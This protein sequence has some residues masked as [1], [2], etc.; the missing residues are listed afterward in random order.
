MRIR[1]ITEAF[2]SAMTAREIVTSPGVYSRAIDLA[3]N[4]Q[5]V[6][7]AHNVNG[8]WNIGFQE[9]SSA[10]DANKSKIAGV[11]PKGRQDM[12]GKGDSQRVMSFVKQS[13]DDFVA[14]Y[15]PKRMTFS[16]DLS[17]GGKADLY[18]RMAQRYTPKDYQLDVT[19]RNGHRHFDIVHKTALNT[20]IGSS[21]Y[22]NTYATGA[23]GKPTTRFQDQQYVK[24]LERKAR[25]YPNDANISAELARYRDL[26]NEGERL[27]TDQ[28]IK[29]RNYTTVWVPRIEALRPRC[30]A[31]VDRII[32]TGRYRGKKP[33]IL[34]GI[35]DTVASVNP[36]VGLVE[37][38]S[39]PRMRIDVTVFWDAP[40]ETLTFVIAHELG[41]VHLG[42]DPTK[43]ETPQQSRQQELAADAFAAEIM[44]LFGYSQASV[45]RFMHSK[46]KKYREQEQ[47]NARPDSTHP[48]YDQR[49]Q[50]GRDMGIKLTRA[51]TDDLKD[52]V[53]RG[54]MQQLQHLMA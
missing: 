51:D 52:Y 12:T 6:F 30:N 45:F 1:E 54:G 32:K 49:I 38:G 9:Q 4:R 28:V 24:D 29:A 11:D 48:T 40:D 36:M 43:D 21:E 8:I 18:Q 20:R 37:L 34:V 10:G 14:K 23:P 7:V 39:L 27:S 13:M 53:S 25:E 16:A 41:H 44:K 5:I 31:I 2:D 3:A 42:H 33:V 35:E 19:Q 50:Q 26:V 47:W 15:Q 17:H 22:S 46:E